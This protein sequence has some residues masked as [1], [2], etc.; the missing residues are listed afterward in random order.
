MS[1]RIRYPWREGAQRRFLSKGLHRCEY[2][3]SRH[4][5]AEDWNVSVSHLDEAGSTL[6]EAS[7]TLV[8]LVKACALIC[9]AGGR[10]N[11][12]LTLL[13]HPHRGC[14]GFTLQPHLV[15][16]PLLH[17]IPSLLLVGHSSIHSLLCRVQS[18]HWL[19]VDVTFLTPLIANSTPRRLRY[20]C[21]T[22]RANK[23]LQ[24]PHDDE[25]ADCLISRQ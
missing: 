4:G 12:R 5:R 18:V 2:C 10:T 9:R 8:Q 17:T 23:R 1:I 3:V 6:T 19:H 21:I 22:T 20:E 13:S 16:S 24:R 11:G 15:P 14:S 7:P 25:R